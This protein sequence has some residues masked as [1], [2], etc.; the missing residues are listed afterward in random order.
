MAQTPA[1]ARTVYLPEYAGLTPGLS[2]G[3]EWPA[4]QPEET[5]MDFSLNIQ[6][7]L[8]DIF[9]NVASFNVVWSP[10]DVGDLVISEA[11]EHQGICTI[12]THSGKPYK[13]YDVT[14]AV[15]SQISG[16]QLVRTVRLPMHG[17]VPVSVVSGAVTGV[18]IP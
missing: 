10:A 1:R 16:Q 15:T 13:A 18:V 17:A 12:I 11:F 3:M 14:F 5:G 6:G 7:W 4:K 2:I 9:D 8:F